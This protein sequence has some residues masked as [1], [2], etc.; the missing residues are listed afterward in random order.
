MLYYSTHR[1]VGFALP[2]GS[3]GA[4]RAVGC[5]PEQAGESQGALLMCGNS[6]AEKGVWQES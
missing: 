4:G 6:L 2:P 1:D 5:P 3:P